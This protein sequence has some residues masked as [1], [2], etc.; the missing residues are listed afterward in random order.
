MG[1]LGHSETQGGLADLKAEFQLSVSRSL[2]FGLG[3]GY[4]SDSDRM[5][6]A[7]NGGMRGGMMGGM[8]GGRGDISSGFDHSF[9]STPLTLTAYLRRPLGARAGVILHGGIGAYFSRYQDVGVQRK[10]AFGPHFGLGADFRIARKVL[11]VGEASYRFVSFKGFKADLHPGFD[12]DEAGNMMSGFWY[13]DRRDGESY[14]R[15]DNGHMDEFR[16]DLPPFDI[17]L[18]GLSLRAGLRFG[19]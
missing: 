4:L 15:M 1:G 13:Y 6:G 14:F 9:R 8:M 5:H 12:V 11:A 7:G 2:S 10:R 3:F 17:N 18:S 19:F 16:R